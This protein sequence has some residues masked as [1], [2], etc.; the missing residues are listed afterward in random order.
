MRL[1]YARAILALVSIAKNEKT[2]LTKAHN[3]LE[4]YS[5]PQRADL[6]K[7]VEVVTGLNCH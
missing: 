7:S 5:A 1:A 2:K 3:E 4:A 6:A